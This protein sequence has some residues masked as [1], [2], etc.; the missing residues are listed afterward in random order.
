MPTPFPHTD[1]TDATIRGMRANDRTWEEVGRKLGCS[2]RLA[3]KMGTEMGLPA[4][5]VAYLKRSASFCH[6]VPT[7]AF[8]TREQS[9]RGARN[10]A[11]T[12]TTAKAGAAIDL[13]AG[14]RS[15]EG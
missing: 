10:A 9:Q 8:I 5:G 2:A 13:N 11:I 15:L 4:R 3:R 1:A 6:M 12:R 7:A 14:L